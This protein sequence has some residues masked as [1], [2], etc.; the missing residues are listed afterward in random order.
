MAEQK[1]VPNLWFD[2]EAEEAANFYASIFK[3]SR[4]GRLDYY[5]D[6]GAEVSGKKKGSVVTVDFELCGQKFV[7]I[8]GGPY[9]TFSPAMSLA[10]RCE[11]VEEVDAIW[12]KLLSGGKVLMDIGEYPFSKRYGWLQDKYGLSWQL[13]H[14]GTPQ[15]IEPNLLFVG[16][17]RGQAMEAINFYLSLFKGSKI[18]DCTL[19]G[20]NDPNGKEGEVMY[21]SFDLAGQTFSAMDGGGEHDFEF[22]GAISFMINCDSQAEIDVFWDKIPAGGGKH[23]QCGWVA[24]RFGVHWQVV[25]REMEKLITIADST[26]REKVMKAMLQMKKLDIKTL[27]QAAR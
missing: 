26:K 12:K 11:T 5:G 9:F 6:S 7:G 2:S 27:E 24:D 15:K 18:N 10:V 4:V 14:C 21:A 17:R 13:I 19:Y 25:P 22:T 3:N 20:P 1:I 8:N 23:Q 16:G